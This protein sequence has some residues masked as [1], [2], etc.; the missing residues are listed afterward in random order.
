M[1]CNEVK[2]RLNQ[3]GFCLAPN[4]NSC[5]IP[6]MGFEEAKERIFQAWEKFGNR[7]FTSIP[8]CPGCMTPLLTTN[9]TVEMG[10]A[11]GYAEY[12]RIGSIISNSYLRKAV[13]FS[14]YVPGN[15]EMAEL[16]DHR[17]VVHPFCDECFRHMGEKEFEETTERNLV[18]SRRFIPH[19][20]IKLE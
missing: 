1:K 7:G 19:G 12:G 13:G 18:L 5:I 17:V 6:K 2:C 9:E 15:E 10:K 8:F 11:F 20:K 3:K 16:L 4:A 14:F